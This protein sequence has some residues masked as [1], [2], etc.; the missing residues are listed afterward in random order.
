MPSVTIGTASYDVYTS[1]AEA[2]DYLNADMARHSVWS[3]ASDDNKKRGLVS[4]TRLIQQAP[5][6]NGQAPSPSDASP[7][8]DL[9]AATSLLAADIVAK[10]SL[11]SGASTASNVKSAGAGSAKVEFF[12]PVSGNLFPDVVM[13]LLA[14]LWAN[15]SGG[16]LSVGG[17]VSGTCQ[18][19]RFD[20]TDYTLARPFW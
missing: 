12:K 13:S 8:L 16:T 9:K 3:A 7:D 14:P 4:A 15:L 10:P 11:S 5:Q 1:V 6:W 2:T 19:S 17:M 20:E 18:Q